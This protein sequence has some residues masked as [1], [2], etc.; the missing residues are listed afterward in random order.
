MLLA[1]PT[2]NQDPPCERASD[3]TVVQALHLMNA[4]G[5]HRKVTHD[6]GRAAKIAASGKPPAEIVEELYL[7]IYSRFPTDDERQA[8]TEGVR[9]E[10]RSP[11]GRPK[12]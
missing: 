8:V 9:R 7:A 5:L 11:P 1:G 4:P 10:L 6:D 3:T 12:T 2:R